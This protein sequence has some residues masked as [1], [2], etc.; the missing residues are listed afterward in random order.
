MTPREKG[1]RPGENSGQNVTSLQAV[2]EEAG[3]NRRTLHR[4][5]AFADAVPE[6]LTSV[7]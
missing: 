7:V 5:A 2:A 1:G 6:G 3:V 4:D